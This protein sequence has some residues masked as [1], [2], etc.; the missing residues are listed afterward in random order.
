[1][2]MYVAQPR[3]VL[4]VVEA[5]CHRKKSEKDSDMLHRLTVGGQA[6]CLSE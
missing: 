2:V 1:M 5:S 4:A 6:A 3:V